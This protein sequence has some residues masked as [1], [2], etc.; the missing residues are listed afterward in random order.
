MIA[1]RSSRDRGPGGL[2]ARG[3]IHSPGEKGTSEI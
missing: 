1:T 2:E 3:E